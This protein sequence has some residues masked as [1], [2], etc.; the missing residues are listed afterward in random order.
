MSGARHI[1]ASNREEYIIKAP[2][3]NHPNVAANEWVV[4]KLGEHLDLPTLDCRVVE[5]NGTRCFG[6]RWMDPNSF[7]GL[8]TT[9]AIFDKCSNKHLVYGL[10]AFDIWVFN[11]DRHEENLIIRTPRPRAGVVPP[12]SF[13]LN[14]HGHC[15]VFPNE[16]GG[17]LPGRQDQYWP[18]HIRLDFIRDRIVSPR[19]L[20]AAIDVIQNVPD[21]VIDQVVQS[22]PAEWLSTAEIG[23]YVSFLK[24][25]R[26][27]LRNV[28]N[29]GRGHL[30]ALGAGAI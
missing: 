30:T 9:E 24:A 29:A 15:L 12:P 17:V 19:H 1:E 16:N 6:S 20:G 22:V 28:I 14:D 5:F 18:G 4:T 11:I 8:G 7:Y 23:L 25:R 2:T 13:L 26:D 21:R 3:P 27:G 10:V